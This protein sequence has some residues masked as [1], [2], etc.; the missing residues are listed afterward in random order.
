[1]W[2]YFVAD[3]PVLTKNVHL[4]GENRFNMHIRLSFAPYDLF[5]GDFL[6]QLYSALKHNQKMGAITCD[7]IE[8]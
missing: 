8:L 5:I 1:M 3:E 6:L 7:Y 4:K 2:K